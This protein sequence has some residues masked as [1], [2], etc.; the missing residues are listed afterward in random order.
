M[1]NLST[2]VRIWYIWKINNL[3]VISSLYARNNLNVF[4]SQKHRLEKKKNKEENME[5]EEEDVTLKRT[6]RL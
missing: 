1:K 3:P 5:E 4:S 2:T 6:G